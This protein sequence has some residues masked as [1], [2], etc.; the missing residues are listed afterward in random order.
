MTRSSG[1]LAS[2]SNARTMVPFFDFIPSPQDFELLAFQSKLLRQPYCLT[3]SAP[4]YSYRAHANL[5]NVYTL[6]INTVPLVFKSWRGPPLLGRPLREA[7]L[8]H[9]IVL[10]ALQLPLPQRDPADPFLA[11]TAQV[12]DL[13]LVTAA[14]NLLRL[15]AI[16]T[17]KT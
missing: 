3:V 11:A 14:D 16:R 6:G 8:T 13:T 12:R 7:P 1:K 15:G 2:R 4:E 17:M 10:I 5:P 9:E